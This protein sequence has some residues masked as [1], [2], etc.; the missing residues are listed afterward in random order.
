MPLPAIGAVIGGVATIGGAVLGSKAQKKAANTAA[1]TAQNTTA[2]NNALAMDFYNR[3]SANMQPYQQTGTAAMGA[4]NA[5]LGI[6]PQ[7]GQQVG[8][9]ANIP[10]FQP[11][12]GPQSLQSNV[13]PNRPG[14]PQALTSQQQTQALSPAARLQSGVSYNALSSALP[15]YAGPMQSNV[16]QQGPLQTSL[17]GYQQLTSGMIGTAMDPGSLTDFR[18]STGYNF[19]VNEGNKAITTNAAA[20][21]SIQS[22]AAAKALQ[23]HG[24]NV[25][26]AEYGNYINQLGNYIGYNDAFA[27]NERGYA[28]A[29]G[30]YLDSFNRDN[31]NFGFTQGQYQDQFALGERGYADSRGQYLDQFNRGERDT[32]N[33]LNMY[34][35]QFAQSER[36]YQDA[37][38]DYGRAYLSDQQRYADQFGMNERAYADSRGDYGRAYDLD[39]GRY[40][41][42][43]AQ[44]ERGYAD[45]RGDYSRAYTDSRR[46][47]YVNQLMAQ[48]GMGL[49]AASALA[50]VNQNALGMITANNNAG[51]SAAANAALAQGNAN[52]QLWAGVAG[53]IGNAVGAWQMNS[54]YNPRP[55]A[56]PPTTAP[57]GFYRA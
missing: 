8:T 35:D 47:N 13:V 49:S 20:L 53:G 15:G 1:Q 19:R 41:D 2:Q 25:A 28:D 29:R 24:Q 50:G 21:G 39:L 57:I 3:N 46:D 4:L 51:S 10:G 55:A 37:R 48:Q 45:A 23:E 7:T 56:L 27:Q 14:A 30:Q 36:G 9:P 12:P 52:Q 6:Q 33:A 54:L 38:G 17:P 5:Q 16:P 34:G 32:R 11:P 18:Q 31:R 42:V 26:S 40:Q 22:G 44:G 43:F